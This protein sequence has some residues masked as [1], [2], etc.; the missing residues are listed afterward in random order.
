MS[1]TQTLE[2]ILAL[3]AM[4]AEVSDDMNV[5]ESGG[6]GKL[7]P[8]GYCMARLVEYIDFGSHVQE[9]KGVAKAAAPEFQL[10]FALYGE[11][12]ANDDGTPYIF[13]P[14]RMSLSR[15]EKAGA[16]LSFKAMNWKKVHKHFAQMVGEAFLV[17]FETK[18]PSDPTKKPRS[19]L[20]LK[21]TLPPLDAVSKQP[22][23]IPPARPED[24]KLFLWSHPDLSTWHSFYQEGKYDDGNSKNV[25]Q[26]TMLSAT[27]FQGSPL[28]LLLATNQVPYTIPAPKAQKAAGAAVA[29]PMAQP[30]AMPIAQPQVAVAQPQVASP[31]VAAVA[32]PAVAPPATPAPVSASPAPTAAPFTPS[33]NGQPEQVVTQTAPVAAVA[34]VAVALPNVAMP[35]LPQVG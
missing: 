18:A 20:N 3:A 23:P 35:A 19:I 22:Y 4:A 6:G 10:A 34:P 32:T 12:Y 27:D 24:L 30:M 9:F 33:P 7:F 5:A 8:E 16:F 14:Y 26:E 21:A 2:Q 17:K 15:N 31:N 13:R 28:Q 1:A 11:G 29:Q 25:V